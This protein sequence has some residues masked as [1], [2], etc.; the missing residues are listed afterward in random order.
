MPSLPVFQYCI[1]KS[2]FQR[3]TLKAGNGPGDEAKNFTQAIKSHFLLM[4]LEV[5]YMREYIY[6]RER[7]EQF[8]N[9]TQDYLHA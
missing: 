6:V 3:A 7:R 1:Q 5:I 4:T 9:L 2:A 8:H